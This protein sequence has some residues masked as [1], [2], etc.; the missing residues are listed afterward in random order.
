MD[1]EAP[2]FRSAKVWVDYSWSLFWSASLL[3]PLILRLGLYWLGL[4][5]SGPR[6]S[7]YFRESFSCPRRQGTLRA[8]LWQVKWICRKFHLGVICSQHFPR[9]LNSLKVH[10]PHFQSKSTTKKVK[11]FLGLIW[12]SRG[13]C[14][15]ILESVLRSS[16]QLSEPGADSE[17]RLNC[18]ELSRN[19]L[20]AQHSN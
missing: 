16:L 10:L 20:W 6:Y 7:E 18:L 19:A 14:L 5:V 15:E 13:D 2:L 11:S 12:I 1:P 9:T 8:R 17:T 3:S 4:L